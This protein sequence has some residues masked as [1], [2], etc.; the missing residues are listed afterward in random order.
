METLY[1]YKFTEF[2]SFVG[3]LMNSV[4]SALAWYKEYA[5]CFKLLD[6]NILYLS[7]TFLKIILFIV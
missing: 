6:P 4:L 2:L 3:Y 5:K 7:E 1:K